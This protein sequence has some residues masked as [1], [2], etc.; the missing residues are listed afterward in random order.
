MHLAAG[1]VGAQQRQQQPPQS[2][3]KGG[4]QEQNPQL[5]A[6]LS[7]EPLQCLGDVAGCNVREPSPIP[8]CVD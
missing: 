4:V 5:A 1:T 3:P 6:A 8:C 7:D 2:Q